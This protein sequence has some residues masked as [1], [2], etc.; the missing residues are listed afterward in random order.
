MAQKKRIEAGEFDNLIP[1]L[2]IVMN[3][4][5][6]AVARRYLVDCQTLQSIAE[7]HG[8]TRQGVFNTV[9]RL[10]GIRNKYL[11]TLPKA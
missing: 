2:K 11:Q 4:K 10:W 1:V 7:E 3:D 5:N 8:I 9:R 6:I